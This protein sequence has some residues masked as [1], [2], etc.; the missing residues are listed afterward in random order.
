MTYKL[1]GIVCHFVSDLSQQCINLKCSLLFAKNT[2]GQLLYLSIGY[3]DG[4]LLLQRVFD[5]IGWLID[6]ILTLPCMEDI[7]K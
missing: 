2:L 7:N 1:T 6:N 5:R 4:L 3:T